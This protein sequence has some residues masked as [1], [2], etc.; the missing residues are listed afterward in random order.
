MKHVVILFFICSFFIPITSAEPAKP[1]IGIKEKL[2]SD[3]PNVELYDEAGNLVPLKSLINKPTLITFVYFRCTGICTPLLNEM[4]TVID[5]MD[6]NLGK[7]YQILTISFDFTDR[8]ETAQEKRDNYLGELKKT[9]D[10][11][12]WRFLTGDSAIVQALTDSMGFFYERS[13]ADWIHPTAVIAV[14]PDGKITRYLYGIHQLPLDVKLAVIEASEGKTGPTISKILNMCY[15]YDPEGQHYTLNFVHISGLV[16]VGLV[17]LFVVVF[18]VIPK[19]KER[20][21]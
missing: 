16:I 12:G 9:V 4:T 21:S 6:L 14:S 13:G 15:T 2:G 3:V 20:R 1:F 10:P 8:P 7:D 5:K 11:N 17:G 18:I 19:K